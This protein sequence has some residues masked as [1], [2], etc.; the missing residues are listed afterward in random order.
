ME[1]FDDSEVREI[2]IGDRNYPELLR[3]I[4]KPPKALRI[5]GHL[6]PNQKIIA[7]SGSRETTQQALDA[8]YRIGKMLA[9]TDIQSSMDLPKG[10]TLLRLRVR[11]QRVAQL[12]VSFRVDS[13]PFKVIQK[14]L[15]KKSLLREGSPFRI[16]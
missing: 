9:N 8:A 12:S 5:R 3:K 2:G 1:R 13:N 6:P 15:L 16:S 4:K 10:A 11:F 14:T 7:I